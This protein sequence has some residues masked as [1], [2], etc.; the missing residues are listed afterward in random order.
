[1]LFDIMPVWQ[2]SAV[3]INVIHKATDID[4]C[5]EMMWTMIVCQ[6]LVCMCGSHFLN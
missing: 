1:M 4:T 3:F 2:L 6:K 5:S